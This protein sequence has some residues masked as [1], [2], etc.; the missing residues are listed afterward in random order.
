MNRCL[1]WL[2]IFQAME[3]MLAFDFIRLCTKIPKT[4]FKLPDYP[5]YEL[6]SLH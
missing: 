6:S 4:L 1:M 3:K 5:L 2:L